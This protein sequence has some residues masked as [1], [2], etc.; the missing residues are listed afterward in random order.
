MALKEKIR[1]KQKK[2]LVLLMWTEAL[3][4]HKRHILMAASSFIRDREQSLVKLFT[5]QKM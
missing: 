1:Q 3:M 2:M 4:Q 5:I